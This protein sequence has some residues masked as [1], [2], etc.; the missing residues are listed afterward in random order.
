MYLTD[1]FMVPMLNKI[2]DAIKRF[3]GITQKD[4]NRSTRE[5]KMKATG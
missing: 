1:D 5:S 4:L 2:A 3:P